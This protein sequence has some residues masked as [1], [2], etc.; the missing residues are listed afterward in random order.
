M[1]WCESCQTVYFHT[2]CTQFL[3]IFLHFEF[4]SHQ[5]NTRLAY[6]ACCV[7]KA[8]HVS[9]QC[10]VGWIVGLG[11]DW[12]RMQA[13]LDILLNV[14]MN[15]T[16]SST[17]NMFFLS[18]KSLYILYKTFLQ[19]KPVNNWWRYGGLCGHLHIY[20]III[21]NQDKNA[22]NYNLIILKLKIKDYRW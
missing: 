5:G 2:W 9:G 16:L 21:C 1:G 3:F 18:L 17:T 8:G 22:S 6:Q 15:L 10:L 4:I 7:F 11:G 14:T 12:L 13:I 20:I 19:K